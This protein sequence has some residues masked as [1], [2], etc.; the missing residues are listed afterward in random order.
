VFQCLAHTLGI[1]PETWRVLAKAHERRN[2]S[3]YEG[4]FEVDD[5]LLKDVLAAAQVVLKSVK[6]LPPLEPPKK[7]S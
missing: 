2:L 7:R 5:R 1:P 3:E 4:V 6:A